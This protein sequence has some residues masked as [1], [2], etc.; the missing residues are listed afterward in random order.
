MR[1]ALVFLLASAISAQSFDAA[2]LRRSPHRISDS[3]AR[4][5]G[6]IPTGRTS[7][8]LSYVHVSVAALIA[9]AYDVAADQVSGPS[10][11]RDD[12]YDVNATFPSETPRAAIAVMLQHLLADRFHLAVREETKPRKG[13]ALVRAGKFPPKIQEAKAGEGTGIQTNFSNVSFRNVT[14]DAFAHFLSTSLR[15][16]V[17][18][19]TGLSAHYNIRL[20]ASMAE[21][22]TGEF[23][24]PLSRIGFRLQG[25]TLPDRLIV[26]E[27]INRSPDDD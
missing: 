27:K 21:I 23:R 25:R 9:V 14:M 12:H 16:P 2:S 10:W 4:S 22:R 5:T 8:R 3:D 17:V 24:A 15:R 13:F 1:I 11:L 7:G 20:D 19:E 6:A 26:V 18:D